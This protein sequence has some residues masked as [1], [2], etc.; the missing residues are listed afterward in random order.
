MAALR[1]TLKRREKVRRINVLAL[2][3]ALALTQGAMA[4][5]KWS[6][7]YR[8]EG[9]FLKNQTFVKDQPV[10]NSYLLN[11]LVLKNEIIP[12]DEVIIRTRF[13]IL[14]NNLGNNQAGQALGQYQTNTNQ[15]NSSATQTRTQQAGTI[16]V[17]ELNFTWNNEFS[18]LRVGRIP[19][20]FG[21]GMT[22]NSG[23]GLFDH[24]LSTKDIV[25]FEIL[26]GNFV[27]MPAYG[28]VRESGFKSEDD[29]NDYIVLV[30]Y[31]N[32]D[33]DL[34]MGFLFNNRVAPIDESTPD[35]GNDFPASY[36]SNGNGTAAI[37]D[38]YN[39][40]NMNF[41][42]KKN[43]DN[44]F[45]G[46]ELGFLQGYSGV[47]TPNAVGSVDRVELSSFG[48]ALEAGYKMGN[49]DL[50][51]NAGLA[52]GDDP[53][54]ATFEG[55]FFHPNYNVAMLM[56]NYPMGQYDVLRSTLA[57]TRNTTTGSA[58][59]IN[60]LDTEVISNA[61]YFAPNFKYHASEKYDLTTGFCYG[62]TQ[63]DPESGMSGKS[64]GLEVDMGLT[65]KPTENFNWQ[66]QIGIMFP[67]AAWAGNGSQN[68][69]RD[70][71]YGGITKAA[72]K[73]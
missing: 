47:K 19:F 41:Y 52:S 26:M 21:L 1:H 24:W 42:V 6:G 48:I 67:G 69:P 27:I 30:N 50:N 63:K 62:M 49:W 10:E 44:F 7:L 34:A 5:L 31:N 45:V 25:G 37:Y 22:Y 29:I 35:A 20:D 53:D 13:D 73:F 2:L 43:S 14:N 72:V 60:G 59:N 40:Y 66:T 71:A 58:K 23:R 61:V 3:G 68:Y 9:V 65:Y 15:T 28:K 56:F 57:G 33:T 70:W 51:L 17:T 36:F 64:L 16:D 11:H 38:G 32:L 18:R 8:A 12:T 4:D 55:Y 39:A 54:T 46:G